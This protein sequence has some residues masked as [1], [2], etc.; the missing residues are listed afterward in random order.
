MPTSEEIYSEAD[1]LKDSGDLE[2]AAKKLT[3]LLAQDPRFAL[4]H[5]ALAV[6]YGRLRRHD[7]AIQHAL[8]VCELEPND[9]FSFTA[10]SVTFQRAGR[11]PEAEEAM[12]RARMMQG[13]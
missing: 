7:E 6:I 11:I 1:K 8:K 12:A 3:E 10:L 4:A 5:S 13:H 2:G 9:T